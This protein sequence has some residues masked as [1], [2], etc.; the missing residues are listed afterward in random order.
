MVD[1]I[2]SNSLIARVDE[3]CSFLVAWLPYRS[4]PESTESVTVKTT[5]EKK[6]KKK[7]WKKSFVLA[8]TRV[9]RHPLYRPVD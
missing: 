5:T 9:R 8:S 6:K 3:A 1:W 7:K 4:P 2:L